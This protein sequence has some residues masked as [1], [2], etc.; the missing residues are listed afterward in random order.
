VTSRDPLLTPASAGLSPRNSPQHCAQSAG[1]GPR[2]SSGGGSPA[3]RRRFVMYNKAPMWNETSQV[4]QLDFG[5]RVT[6][7]SAKNFQIEFGGKQVSESMKITW[8]VY[9]TRQLCL[10]TC[11]DDWLFT[12][13]I[14][15]GK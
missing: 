11:K 15:K 7:E 1:G 14:Y 9:K 5:G 3:A 8:S 2:C 6:Q 13:P 12:K 10:I 4:Y